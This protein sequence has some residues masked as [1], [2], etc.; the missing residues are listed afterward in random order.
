M[1]PVCVS[2]YKSGINLSFHLSRM[3]QIHQDF[4]ETMESKEITHSDFMVTVFFA[5]YT[6]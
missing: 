5:K 1:R 3:V 2:E 6:V 4:P